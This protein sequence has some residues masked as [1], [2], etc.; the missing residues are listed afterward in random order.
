MAKHQHI[1]LNKGLG[2]HFLKDSEVLYKIYRLIEDQVDELPLLEVGPGAGALS[3]YLKSRDKYKLVEFDKRFAEYL[4]IEFPEL[5]GKILNED[6]LLLDL[7]GIFD[8][9]FAIVGNF[10][11]NISSQIIF[12]ALDYKE[13]V[14]LLIGMFQKEVARRI[15][16][17]EGSKEYGIISVLTQVFYDTEYLFDV[18]REAFN[19]PPKV[20]SGVMLMRRKKKDY[21]LNPSFFKAVVKTAFGQRRKTLRNSLKSF[22]KTEELRDLDIFEQRPEQLSVAAFVNLSNI[23]EQAQ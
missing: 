7:N 9:A 22:L 10:P 2:Q 11:Y 20:V 16:A 17:K 21:S 14:P 15:C 23:L 4:A 1:H 6:F 12:K 8:E 13:Q 3:A 5:K 18:P 19:P